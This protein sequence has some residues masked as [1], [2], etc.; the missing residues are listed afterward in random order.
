MFISE[1]KG[2]PGKST[3]MRSVVSALKERTP[4][5]PM[6]LFWCSGAVTSLDGVYLPQIGVAIIDGSHPH[7]VEPELPGAADRKS[8]V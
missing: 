7:C 1:L 3:L 2:G 6:E 8:V 4:D 5:M